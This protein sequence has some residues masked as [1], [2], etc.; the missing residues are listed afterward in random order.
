M[1][2]NGQDKAA[3]TNFDSWFQF[4]C[5]LH[6]FFEHSLKEHMKLDRV[7]RFHPLWLK[8]LKRLNCHLYI[9][10]TEEDVQAQPRTVDSILFHRAK[11]VI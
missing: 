11:L 3:L 4:V 6:K 8:G 2:S 5:K 10:T 7:C 9:T 1:V